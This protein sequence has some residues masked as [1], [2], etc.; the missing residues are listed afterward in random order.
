MTPGASPA[1]SLA[2]ASQGDAL[3]V[4]NLSK[5][6]GG[7]LALDGV[8]LSVGRREVHGLLGSNGSGKSTLIKILAGFH[9]PEPGGRVRLFGQELHLPISGHNARKLGLAFVHQQLG[10]IPS[11]SLTENLRISRLT[12][13]TDW[14]ISWRNEHEA[15]AE[16]FRRYGLSF[17]PRAAA[18]SLSWVEQALFAIVRA[19][20]DLSSS[21]RRA[22]V[23]EFSTSRRP[24]CRASAS[25][26]CSPWSDR[27][28]W[29]A[30][31]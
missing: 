11:L 7:A 10:L 4:E 31:A 28:L 13:T 19:V 12:S 20:E 26:N 30:P 16:V 8:S 25:I 9:A 1:A 5:R 23:A 14:R 3:V 2:S 27:S 22:R 18:G 17:D 24:F 6:F 21:R 15:A 29:T